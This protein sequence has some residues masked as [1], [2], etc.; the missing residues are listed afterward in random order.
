MAKKKARRPSRVDDFDDEEPEEEEEEIEEDDTGQKPLSP[1]TFCNQ[2]RTAETRD[3][4]R[5]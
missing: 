3:T 1:V 4:P 2:Q 5:T